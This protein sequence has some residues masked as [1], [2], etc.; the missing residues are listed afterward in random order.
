[1]ATLGSSLT[2]KSGP[3]AQVTAGAAIT[4]G[5]TVYRDTAGRYQ[6]T[7]GDASSATAEVA[8]VALNSA[9]SGQ[10][11]LIALAGAKLENCTS[12][13]TGQIYCVASA[14]GDVEAHSALTDDT[15]YVSPVGV[16]T[17]TTEITLILAVSGV[18]LNLA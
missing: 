2:L 17:S 6:L 3:T 12:L 5:Q 9:A 4:A 10:P 14:A 13:L 8:G 16:A 15:D 18:K 11:L 1:M 7:D